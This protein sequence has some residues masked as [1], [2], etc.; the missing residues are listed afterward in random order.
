[1]ATSR[2][3]TRRVD[4]RVQVGTSNKPG[5]GLVIFEASV[6]YI[7]DPLAAGGPRTAIPEPVAAVL[8][9]GGYACT[10][11]ST[12]PAKAGERGVALF[13]TDS[14]GEDGGDW[15][16][17][18][19]PQLRSVNGIQMANAVPAFSFA[20]PTGTDS[21]DLAKVQKVPASPGLGTEAAL[22]L[23]VRAEK[24]VENAVDIVRETVDVAAE[25]AVTGLVAGLDILEESDERVPQLGPVRPGWDHIEIGAD[26]TIISGVK[27]NG[28]IY[29]RDLESPGAVA[30]SDERLP[31][32]FANLGSWDYVEVDPN[33]EIISGRRTDGS[34]YFRNLVSPNLAVAPEVTLPNKVAGFGD[35]MLAD[36]GGLGTTTLSV[37]SAELGVEVF[38]GGVPGQTST[39]VALRQGGLD[40]FLTAA[41]NLIPA[42]GPVP[43]VVDQPTG[44]WKTGSI[45]N[46]TGSLAGVKGV[47]TK[48]AAEAWTFTRAASGPAVSVKPETRWVSTEGSTRNNW[49]Q[50]WRCGRNNAQPAVIA[51]DEKSMRAGLASTN[52]NRFLVLPTYNMTSEPAGS[53][54]Y[55][56]VMAI[57]AARAE[58]F[59]PNYYDMRGWIIRNGLSEAGISPT[60]ADTLAISE[61]R[62][63]PS[64]MHDGTHLNVAGR[65]I[66]GKRL[67][68]ILKTKGMIS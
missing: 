18:A 29:I 67:A 65:T 13:T 22:A 51:R 57:N 55:A 4:W 2:L 31:Q 56:N 50:I 12:N 42:S 3:S 16:W 23:V 7:P 47:L 58:T 63:P 6:S 43:V 1:M 46:F 68:Q 33:D 60:A 61:D 35:S 49:V 25:V 52:S 24:A 54:G 37:L 27:T 30:S 19:R 62:I 34:Y 38:S 59:G 20:V 32:P 8:D 21:L 11:D 26:G 45:W 66:E 14:L 53:A 17:T 64:L 40:V 36:H 39:E 48:S 10:P 28:V 44:T 15:T 41:G 9:A 5:Q